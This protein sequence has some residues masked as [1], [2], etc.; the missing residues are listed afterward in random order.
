MCKHKHFHCHGNILEL[1]ICHALHL[2]LEIKYELHRRT[3]CSP[4]LEILGNFPSLNT[5]MICSSYFSF[6]QFHF[7]CVLI[8]KKKLEVDNLSYYPT[9]NFGVSLLKDSSFFWDRIIGAHHN[10]DCFRLRAFKTET[11]IGIQIVLWQF[12]IWN[13]TKKKMAE[14]TMTKINSKLFH[15][16]KK[17]EY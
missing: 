4:Y 10:D 2:K 9:G 11:K 8:K 14:C 5:L 15:K 17:S 16:C 3:F 13:N 12:G 1:G 7:W 6:L